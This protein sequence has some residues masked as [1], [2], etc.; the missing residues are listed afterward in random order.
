MPSD[1][2]GYGTSAQHGWPAVGTDGV[3]TGLLRTPPTIVYVTPAA[4]VKLSARAGADPA[5]AAQI[6]TTRDVAKQA[7]IDHLPIGR[8]RPYRI[9]GVRL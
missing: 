1:P 3:E 2:K 4:H 5:A 8:Q 9:D 7:D 6:A